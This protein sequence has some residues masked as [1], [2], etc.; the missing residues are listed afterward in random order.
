MTDNLILEWARDVNLHESI[1]APDTVKQTSISL[2]YILCI[3][4]IEGSAVD[5]NTLIFSITLFH[6]RSSSFFGRTYSFSPD[7]IAFYHSKVIDEEAMGVCEIIQISRENSSM[8]KKLLGWCKLF[9]FTERNEEL[10]PIFSGSSRALLHKE[11]Q[12]QIPGITLK[13]DV[14]LYEDLKIIFNIIPPDTFFGPHE[15]IPGVYNRK[16]VPYKP[17]TL[18]RSSNLTISNI[19]VVQGADVEQKVM[20]FADKYQREKLRNNESRRSKV[21]ERRVMV[22]T[23]N[24]WT[25]I[26]NNG[27]DSSAAL[28]IEDHSLITSGI[29]SIRD[30][31][32]DLILAIVFEVQ[33]IL[34]VPKKIGESDEMI[35]INIGWAA[36]VGDKEGSYKIGLISGPG[37]SI[38]GKMLW[39]VSIDIDISFDIT[40]KNSMQIADRPPVREGTD[41][42][43]ILREREQQA[44]MEM[45]R[46]QDTIRKLQLD[47][48]KE[49]NKPKEPFSIVPIPPPDKG[50]SY[51]L[52]RAKDPYRSGLDAERNNPPGPYSSGLDVERNRPGPYSSGLDAE[53]NKPSGAYSSGPEADRTR[54]KD[55]YLPT[56]APSERRLQESSSQTISKNL[57][58]SI[59]MLI[60]PKYSNPPDYSYLDALVPDP[61]APQTLGTVVSSDFPKPIS[62]ADKARLVRSGIRGLLDYDH[63]FATYQPRLDVEAQDPLKGSVFI[64]QFL[65]YRQSTR[66]KKLP[67][68]ICFGMRF[69]TF[70]N[71]VTETVHIKTGDQGKP[72]LIEKSGSSSELV[73]KYEIEPC[74]WDLTDFAKYLMKKSLTIEIWDSE[75]HMIVGFVRVHLVELMRQGKPSVVITKEF[76]ILEDFNGEPIGSLQILMR[77]VG[78]QSSIRLQP[79]QNPLKINGGQARH[80]SKLKAKPLIVD[81]NEPPNPIGNDE[82]RKRLRVLEYKKSLKKPGDETWEQEKQINEISMIRES[83]KQTE[84]KKALKEYMNNAQKLFVRAGQALTFQFSLRNPHDH[85]ECFTFVIDDTE[86]QLVKDPIEWQWWA[87]RLNY[88][89]PL[90]YDAITE[91]NS[92]VLRPGEVCPVVFKYL[93]WTPQSK[94]VSV[95]INQSRGSPLCA[96]ELDIVPEASPID[97]LLH[98]YECESRTVRL[99]LPPLFSSEIQY[100]PIIQCSYPKTVVQ[101]ETENEISIEIKV[102]PAPNVSTFNIVVFESIYC[103]E[104]KANWEVKLHSLV[105]MDVSVTMG[106]STSIRITCPGDEARTVSLFSS[107]IDVVFFPPPHNKPFTLMPRT[108]NNL[109]V[110]VRSDSPVPQN[111]RVHCVDVF[112]KQ[113]VYAWVF[114]IQTSGIN[115]TQT[116]D[117]KCPMKSLTEKRV[118]FTNRSQTWAMFHFRSSNPKILEIKDPRMALEG[119]AK[120]YLAIL[121]TPPSMP[122]TAEVS[123]FANDSEENIFECMLFKI[124]FS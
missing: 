57:D 84:I 116:F 20:M 109:P 87:T 60:E 35:S 13:Y 86:L 102:P 7:R 55:P 110:I 56:N 101:W 44:N 43:N 61:K 85:E 72:W 115:V 50:S 91:E 100:K 54:G 59:S 42:K 97:Y 5:I 122:S 48:E 41:Y 39:D 66:T 108:V 75:T 62:R 12:S 51:G 34:L 104:I 26:G 27:P 105:G 119:G 8:S 53:R 74:E 36:H 9:C 114:K 30:V 120:G 10:S 40:F 83:R 113:L 2:P 76:A 52:D 15:D 21:Q 67:D 11:T 71:T 37:R 81:H 19:C 117:L 64:I 121:I 17:I 77:N 124:D 70:N 47:L 23:H 38:S 107:N 33:Y 28:R 69:Y 118:L 99:R 89:K 96:I 103:E 90:E 6:S 45:K 80:K 98:Y 4:S 1:P 123:L 16:V 24:T 106:Q 65:A 82:V 93:S 18:E 25:Y 3:Q 73:V 79:S 29:I 95:W 46:M 49:K 68:N 22:G 112:H 14:K 63:S 31:P 94:L 78:V 111:V 92:I 58:P 88:D 32:D